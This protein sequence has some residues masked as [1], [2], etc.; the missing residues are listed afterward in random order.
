MPTLPP[1]FVPVIVPFAGLFRHRT[2]RLA[3]ALLVGA[4]LAP[5][6]RT[7][8]SVL[9]ILGLAHERRFCRYDRVLSR[10]VWSPR[11]ASR[12]LLTLLVRAFALT[13]PLVLGIDDTR[14]L[15]ILSLSVYRSI[16]AS[17]HPDTTAGK[18]GATL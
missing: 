14:A 2:W 13:G 16:V 7:V 5:D 15:R 3:R 1:R 4:I 8:T 18:R 17:P 12:L 10:A 9:R 11:A 6:V